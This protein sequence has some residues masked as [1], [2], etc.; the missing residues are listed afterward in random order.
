MA[1]LK[2]SK[3]ELA[4]CRLSEE[5]DL[6]NG[7][8][9]FLT[10]GS[11]CLVRSKDLQKKLASKSK[12]FLVT[13][14]AVI[15]Q[16]FLE[17]QRKLNKKF[18]IIAD[19]PKE[20]STT[21]FESFVLDGTLFKEDSDIHVVD[22]ITY[23]ALTNVNDKWY[24]F[25]KSSI[26]SSRPLD[27]KF[28]SASFVTEIEKGSTCYVLFDAIGNHAKGFIARSYALKYEQTNFFLTR[29]EGEPQGEKYVHSIARFEKNEFA[30]GAVILNH[31]GEFLGVL[32][33][34]RG[35]IAPVSAL[36]IFKKG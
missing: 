31:D 3:A 23:I 30:H 4:I 17:I 36:E 19:F 14:D 5:I 7:T 18:K 8:T 11:A 24:S 28:K 32:R 25:P 35:Q 34:H 1:G 15:D 21:G 33:F 29:K 16:K 22:G 12:V 10:R 9:G 13:S 6:G 26:V 27:F 2:R 20:G